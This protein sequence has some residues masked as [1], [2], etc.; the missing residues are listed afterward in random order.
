MRKVLSVGGHNKLV[1]LPDIYN[2]WKPVLLDIDP[3]GKPDVLCD[4][5][6]LSRLPAAEFDAIYCSHN[7]EHYYRHD[8]VKVLGG[9]KHAMKPDA[10][11]HIRV[12]DM[13]EVMRLVVEKKLDIEDVLY[14]SPS[15]PITPCDVIYGYGVEIERSGNDFFAHKIGFT[16][17]SL[18]AM[19]HKCGFPSIFLGVQD[20]EVIAFAFK[21]KP[22][23]FASQLLGLPS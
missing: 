8:V 11:V 14:E 20:L 17:K 7:L 16:Q 15:G 4:A 22:S 18:G 10:F 23:Q 5:R 13:A 6:D 12:P 19:L 1:P 2:G 3:K 21:S 9:F